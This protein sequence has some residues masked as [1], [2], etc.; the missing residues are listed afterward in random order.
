MKDF[1][2]MDEIEKQAHLVERLEQMWDNYLQEYDISRIS[3]LGAVRAFEL[4]T[5]QTWKTEDMFDS[6]EDL[7]E[8]D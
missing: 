7:E 6:G 1:K 8:D 5:I 4:K 3:F 2:E